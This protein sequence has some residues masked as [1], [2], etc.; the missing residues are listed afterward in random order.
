MMKL[1]LQ[2]FEASAF[3]K[4][5]RLSVRSICGCFGFLLQ[6]AVVT[7]GL[8]NLQIIYIVRLAE[9]VCIVNSANLP[10]KSYETKLFAK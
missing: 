9:K 4:A 3:S 10:G 6:L 8:G 1:Q 5:H 2:I 7:S